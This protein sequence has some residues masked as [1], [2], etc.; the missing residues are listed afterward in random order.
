MK[1]FG[2]GK[3]K[4]EIA[5]ILEI[6]PK[7]V[8]SI[9]AVETDEAC[10]RK[11]TK[12]VDPDLL[13]EV[14]QNTNGYIQRAHEILTEEHKIDVAYSTLT[15]L[16][17]KNGL[18]A[19]KDHLRHFSVGDVPG[20]EMQQDTSTYHIKLGDRSYRL[21]ASGLYLRYCK[22]RFIKFYP[23]FNRFLMKCFFHEALTF[24]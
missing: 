12:A 23:Y 18:L 4:K 2:Q 8:R 1:L 11:D 5:R 10:L 22:M 17:R 16:V 21:I 24:L 3:S 9:L 13:R 20:E 7:S 6:D 15:R 14:L 19:N